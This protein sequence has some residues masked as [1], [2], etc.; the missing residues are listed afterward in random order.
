M[1]AP[2]V[3]EVKDAGQELD[4]ISGKI[5]ELVSSGV[6][7]KDIC[8]VA[9]TN[10]LTETYVRDL[11]SDKYKIPCFEIRRKK[12]DDR[13]Q[14]GVRVATMH[15]VKGLEFQYVF[16]V[17]VNEGFVPLPNAIVKTDAVSE[18]E[19]ITAEKCLLYVALT[20]A[21]KEAFITCYGKKSELLK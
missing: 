21:Q 12:L 2:I 6:N 5:N 11:T 14:N 18:Q 7:L 19:T 10:N 3:K 17:A 13:S 1:V 15:R 8:I 20:R 16:V 4:F 9:R